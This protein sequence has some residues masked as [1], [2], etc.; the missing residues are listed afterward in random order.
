MLNRISHTQKI[1]SIWLNLWHPGGKK[2][3]LQE[4]KTDTGCQEVEVQRRVDY[5]VAQG[6]VLVWWKCL[7]RILSAEVVIQLY[8]FS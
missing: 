4:K 7:F 3:K 1:H 8:L 5:R 2:T 6:N